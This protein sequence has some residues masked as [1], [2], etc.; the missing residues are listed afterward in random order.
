VP[1]IEQLEQQRERIQDDLRGVVAG[2]VRSDDVFRHIYA[3]DGSVYEIRPLCVVRPRT[4]ADVVGCVQYAA[5]KQIPIHARGAGS[6]MA[7]ESLGPGVVIDFSRYLRRIIRIDPE[8]VRVQAGVVH[9]QLNAILRPMGRMLAPDPATSSVSTIGS[10]I[11]VDACGSR[12]LKYGSMR[13]HVTA[14][15]VV[16]ADGQLLDVS[17]EPIA[18]QPNDAH[19]PRKRELVGRMASLLTEHAEPIRQYRAGHPWGRAGYELADVLADDCVDLPRLLCGSEGTLAMITEATLATVPLPRYRGVVLLLFDSLEKA[20]RTALDLLVHQPSACD[21]MDRRHLTLVRESDPH[22]EQLIP[23]DAEAA[24][25]VEQEGDDSREL[26]GRLDQLADEMRQPNRRAFGVRQTIDPRETELF[27]QLANRFQPA[28]YRLKGPQ[29]PV[30]V[31]EDMSVPPESLPEFLVRLQNVLKRHEITAST[32][33]HAGHGQVRIRPF[34]DMGNPDDLRK[35]PSLATD[36]YREVFDA[37]GSVGGENACGLSRTPFLPEQY[38]Q[39]Y[40]VLRQVKRVFDPVGILNPGKIIVAEDPEQMVRNLRPPIDGS[41]A[42]SEP[43]GVRPVGLRDLVEL[44]LNWDPSLVAPATDACNGCGD[45]RSQSRQLRMCPIFRLGP[46]EE[47]SPRAKA[48]LVR[49]VLSGRLDLATLK[50]DE[51]K[52]MADLC[53]HCHMC[54]SECPAKVDIP[55]L[56]RETKGA[57]V[58][59]NG[60]TLADWAMTRLDLLGSLA[61]LVS[62]ATNWAIGNRQMRWLMEKTLGIAQGRKLP[63]VAT[64]SF[65]RRAQ[66][67]RLHRPSRRSGRKVL[68]FVDTYAN[69]FDPQLAE[70]LVAILEH[71][72]VDV[73]VHSGQKGAGMSAIATGALDYARRLAAHNTRILADAVRQGYQIVASEPAAALCLSHEYPQLLDDDDA[74]FVAQHTTEACSYLWKMH[75]LGALRLDFKPVNTT[76]GY[77]APCHL[78]ALQVG[79]PGKSL[80]SLVPGLQVLSVEEGC[81]GM[82]G[83]F[84][85]LRRNYRG[86]LRAGWPLISRLRDE[87]IVAGTTE[88][89]ACKMQMEQGAAKATIHP[90]KIL[91]LA[92]GLMPE[93]A[94]WLTATPEA[95]IVT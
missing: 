93:V 60:L 5:E 86:S 9:E 23:R 41:P 19:H 45:C 56:M 18:P 72:G 32:F 58:A 12:R 78:K 95:L 89:S 28:F 42:T 38:G 29:R 6:G 13:K 90:L 63:R 14:L 57:Y 81:S 46:G 7:G 49:G 52:A 65:L 62:C 25:L 24:L 2:D 71:N 75:T 47:A 35:L 43:S 10:M 1:S 67:R 84:G 66:R 37:H 11:A 17:R 64:R 87:S 92:Y 55:N 50:S 22:L 8:A 83:T 51:F 31:C 73:Y 53:V 39:L 85:M 44:Q 21:L 20:A 30:P 26:R 3:T 27:W 4:V 33:A 68:Y 91:A 54:R 76:L 69:Y 61:S 82:A 34:L 79:T 74:Q 70:A 94:H 48:N 80:L 16:L 40:D 77:H 88:C 36:L 59:A 15:Q